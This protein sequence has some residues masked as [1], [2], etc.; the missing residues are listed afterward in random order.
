MKAT[1]IVRR[2]D[3]L[4]RVMIPKEI[5]RTLRI[6]EGD[7]LEVFVQEGGVF[8]K[9]YSPFTGLNS[10]AEKYAD[11]LRETT[12]HICIITDRDN[13]IAISGISK[14]D[15]I[16]K[17]ISKEIEDIIVNRK[18]LLFNEV[19]IDIIENPVKHFNSMI[20]FPIIS[21][22]ETI[23]SVILATLNV[24]VEMEELDIKLLKNAATFLGKQLEE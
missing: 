20:V 18:S 19:P 7:P 14:R 4:G 5:R 6:R 24:D 12:G 16:E 10:F 15:F 21:E 3:D 1:G 9:K 22:G 13:I 11:S 8:F 2:I 23:G 17:A